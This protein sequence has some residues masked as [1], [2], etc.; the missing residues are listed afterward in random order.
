MEQVV[1]VDT[2]VSKAYRVSK[3]YKVHQVI[4][5]TQVSVQVAI[6]DKMV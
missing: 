1:I 2:A 3:A 4:Q 6:Q 5:D